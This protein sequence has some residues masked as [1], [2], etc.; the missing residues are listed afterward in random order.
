LRATVRSSRSTDDLLPGDALGYFIALLPFAT[1]AEDYE[2]LLDLC[3]PNRPAQAREASPDGVAPDISFDF[4][5]I[6][7]PNAALL[8]V[9][10]IS[11]MLGSAQGD[12]VE[13]D[14]LFQLLADLTD[15]YPEVVSLAYE[16]LQES[17]S[18]A[19]GDSTKPTIIRSVST[20]CQ[21]TVGDPVRS[22]SIRGSASTLGVEDIG[23]SASDR[24]KSALDELGMQGL[25]KNF[26]FMSNRSDISAVSKWVPKVVARIIE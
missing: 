19:L 6:R 2:M 7:D 21:V 1:T 22:I 12:D 23:P 11:T 26:H 8:T 20:I 17:I 10:F 3:V 25:L 24:H 15:P 18:R 14:I 5:N 13:T 16:S 4:L 9:S